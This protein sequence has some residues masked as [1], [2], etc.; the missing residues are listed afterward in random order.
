MLRL[1]DSPKPI[2]HQVSHYCEIRI[3]EYEID[4]F[5]DNPAELGEIVLAQFKRCA[6]AVVGVI[7]D[8][9]EE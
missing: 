1:I 3:P 2:T 8:D 6:V 9:E 5:E 7:Y 4:F